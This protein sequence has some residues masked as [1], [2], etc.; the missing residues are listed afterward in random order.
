MREPQPSRQRKRTYGFGD[1]WDPPTIAERPAV[2]FLHRH[3]GNE[4]PSNALEPSGKRI[5]IADREHAHPASPASSGANLADQD[6]RECIPSATWK[7]PVRD[8]VP[9]QIRLPNTQMSP[10]QR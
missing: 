6:G 1:P 5:R 3:P 10:D 7:V 2:P 8:T 4:L 9:P